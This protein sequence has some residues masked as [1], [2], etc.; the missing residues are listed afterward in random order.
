MAAC[1]CAPASEVARLT[2]LAL[3]H[4]NTRNADEICCALRRRGMCLDECMARLSSGCAPECVPVRCCARLSG[5]VEEISCELSRTSCS[6]TPADVCVTAS[7]RR[8]RYAPLSCLGVGPRLQSCVDSVRTLAGC[9]EKLCDVYA[10]PCDR[11]C[12]PR[13]QS[14][15]CDPL[16]TKPLRLYSVKEVGNLVHRLGAPVCDVCVLKRRCI[17]GAA[18]PGLTATALELD[19]LMSKRAVA[20]VRTA[21]RAARLWIRLARSTTAARVT[22]LDLRSWLQAQGLRSSAISRLACEFRELTAPDCDGVVTFGE[23]A[24]GFCCFDAKLRAA[25]VCM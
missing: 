16:P 13:I 22:E 1:Y 24:I 10:Q 17:D 5:L 15:C 12:S 11:P 6:L 25:G 14:A 20:A 8:C 18:L 9:R 19:L 7:P 3:K 23:L 4:H 2:L 21:Q